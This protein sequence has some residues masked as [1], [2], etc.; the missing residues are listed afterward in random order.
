MLLPH[1][2]RLPQIADSAFVEDSARVI[3]DVTLGDKSSVWF[4][5]VIRGD[6]NFIRIGARTNV[7]D[8]TVIHVTRDTHPTVIGDDVTIGHNVT[9]HG[10]TVKDRCLI[11]MGAVVLDGAIIG[12]DS[13]IAAGS[14]VAP[15]TVVPPRTLAVGAPARPKRP[16]SDQEVSHLAASA[17]N[18]IEYMK[19]YHPE[20]R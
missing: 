16:L 5:V 7:Q 8:G 12:E 15:G 14:V 19:D 11:G 4:N 17:G 20:T 13:M 3:G 6:V 9:L 2:E 1:R 10:C 18:Y